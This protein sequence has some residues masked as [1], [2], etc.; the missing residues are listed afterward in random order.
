[1]SEKEQKAELTIVVSGTPVTLEVNKNQPLKGLISKALKEASEASEPDQWGFFIEEG[2]DMVEL[3][4]N[5]KVEDAL[6]RGL[7]VYLNKKAGAAG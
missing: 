2:K 1:M 5:T 3:D 7:T 4:A 6:E